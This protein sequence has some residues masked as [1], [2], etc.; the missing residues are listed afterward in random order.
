[1]RRSLITGEWE[2]TDEDIRNGWTQEA[3]VAY[4][5]ERDKAVGLVSGMV[6]TPLV[7]PRP[8]VRVQNCTTYDPHRAWK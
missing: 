3:A 7:R 8:A 4:Q 2:V 1:M 6:I 5:A